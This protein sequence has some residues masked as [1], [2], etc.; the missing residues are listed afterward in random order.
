MGDNSMD[1]ESLSEIERITAKAKQLDANDPL[2][3][4]ILERI[5]KWYAESQQSRR[6]KILRDIEKRAQR[7]AY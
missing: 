6:E 2:R 3:I 4:G 1:V 7:L 5:A